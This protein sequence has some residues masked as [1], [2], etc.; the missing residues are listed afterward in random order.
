MSR[1]QFRKPPGVPLNLTR[2]PSPKSNSTRG[3]GKGGGA[4][5]RRD[6][7]DEVAE[8]VGEVLRVTGMCGSPSG[9]VGVG[10]STCV[11]GEL[12]GGEESG[13]SRAQLTKQTGQRASLGIN[14]GVCARNWRTAHQIARSTRAGG[15]PKSGEDDLGSPVKFCRVQGLGK[16][17]KLLAKLSERLARLGSDWIGLATVAEARVAMA[18][19]KELVGAKEGRLAGE[20][21][22]RV[23]WGAPGR[24]L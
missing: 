4:Y 21:E 9:M 7:S 3:G 5:Q 16:L 17:H 15:R 12:V 23:R 18:G 22:H 10:R 6:C 1:W 20:G 2:G 8:G 11:G 19:E 13:L 14:G 24:L